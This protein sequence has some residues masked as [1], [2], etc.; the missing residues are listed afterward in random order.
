MAENGYRSPSAGVGA[1][2]SGQIQPNNAIDGLSGQWLYSE[3]PRLQISPRRRAIVRQS[4]A[5]G[6]GPT[7]VTV[8]T[9]LLTPETFGLDDAILFDSVIAAVSATAVVSATP[10]TV[11]GGALNIVTSAVASSGNAEPIGQV[12]ATTIEPSLEASPPAGV[13]VPLVFVPPQQPLFFPIRELKF[14]QFIGGNVAFVLPDQLQIRVNI[15]FNVTI[16]AGTTVNVYT[17][18]KY[19]HVSGVSNEG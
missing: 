2:V 19:R 11:I 6:A 13:G 5:S 8:P 4:T 9:I 1:V 18:F 15:V 10:T 7:V 14:N 16:V 12:V 17:V 3:N